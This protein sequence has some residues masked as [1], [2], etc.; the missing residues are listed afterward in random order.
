MNSH[1]DQYELHLVDAETLTA[2]VL[3]A[4]HPDSPGGTAIVDCEV[5]AI[6][7][8]CKRVT[9]GALGLVRL[10]EVHRRLDHV[11]VEGVAALG[12][13]FE[14]NLQYRLRAYL[15][16]APDDPQPPCPPA[17][18]VRV[19]FRLV[20]GQKGARLVGDTQRAKGRSRKA[21]VMPR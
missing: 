19:R 11:G 7:P 18:Q 9:H 17:P 12:I 6:L 1:T 2:Q 20:H 3:Q 10:K 8:T 4:T 15:R 14:K 13:T 21:A 5:A 16:S